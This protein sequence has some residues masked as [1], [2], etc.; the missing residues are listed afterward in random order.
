MDIDLLF[1][2]RGEAG[3]I[4]K[5]NLVTK[6]VGSIF[7]P[8]SATLTLELADMDYLECNIPIDSDF[9]ALLDNCQYLHIGSVKQGQIGQAYQVSLLI[10]ND[11]YRT[12][13]A[14]DI[15]F[16]QIPLRAFE[17]FVRRCTQG[18]PIHREDLGNEDTMGCVL[19]DASPASL[20]F[21]PHLARRHAL[22]ARPS[23]APSAAPGMGLG[24]RGGGSGSTYISG[25]SQSRNTQRG[26]GGGQS[27]SSEG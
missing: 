23:A 3:L 15:A 17:L 18:Q 27:G 1:T 6:A 19:G 7:D 5:G 16:Q 2:E 20:Q 24:T 14:E 26:Q 13:I 9:G 11:P 4:C 22:E 10:A 25:Q 8:P 21:A 12:E